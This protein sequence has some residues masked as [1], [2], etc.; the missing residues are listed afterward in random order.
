MNKLKV[1][2]QWE[3]HLIHPVSKTKVGR[4]PK[5]NEEVTA[6]ELWEVW[7]T[8]MGNPFMVDDESNVIQVEDR[9][10]F[11]SRKLIDRLGLE[12]QWIKPD[13]NVG[14]MGFYNF[15]DHF[16][17]LVEYNSHPSRN[18]HEKLVRERNQGVIDWVLDR[19]YPSEFPPVDH[20]MWRAN[21]WN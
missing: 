10:I 7:E 11:L 3:V 21:M 4:N 6:K 13:L 19:L 18:I 12:P 15:G 9:G 16:D 2:N 17:E 5:K 14:R 20:L 1:K 8:D